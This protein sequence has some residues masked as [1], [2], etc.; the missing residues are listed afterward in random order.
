MQARLEDIANRIGGTVIGDPSLMVANA[1][2]LQ[3]ALESDLTLLDSTQHIPRFLRSKSPAAIVRSSDGQAIFERS[4]KPVIAVSDLHA[5]FIQA[6]QFLRPS[7]REIF[8][9][10]HPLAIVDTT[11][12]IANDVYIGPNA[13]IGRNCSIAKGARI[14]AGVHLMEGCH[15]GEDCEIFPGSVLYPGTVLG[16]RVILHACVVLGAYGFGYSLRDG[17]HERSAQLGWVELDDDVEV[18]ANTTIDRGTYGPTRIGEGTKLDNQI[19]IGHNVHLGKHN[20][21]CAQVGIAGSSSTGDYVV[22]GGQ[23]GVRDHVHLGD[24]CSAAA[25][26]GIARD[27]NSDETVMGT[28][29]IASRDSTQVWILSQRLPEMKKQLKELAAAIAEIQSQLS[30]SAELRSKAA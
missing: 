6:I 7:H 9:G 19:Q 23:V 20:L 21:M 18:G 5:A 8:R 22:L 27:L 14:H 3:D 13:T 17:R 4:K 1:L 2:P 10:I 11:A 15:V 26:S 29:A 24:R 30:P 25:Q 12:S 16:K 28:P